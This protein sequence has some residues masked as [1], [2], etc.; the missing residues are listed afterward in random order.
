MQTPATLQGSSSSAVRQTKLIPSLCCQS[1]NPVLAHPPVRF[2]HSSCIREL[3]RGPRPAPSVAASGTNLRGHRHLFSCEPSEPGTV[4]GDECPGGSLII[5]CSLC[6]RFRSGPPALR[7]RVGVGASDLLAFSEATLPAPHAARRGC[8]PAVSCQFNLLPWTGASATLFA[9]Q[10]GPPLPLAHQHLC[11]HSFGPRRPESNVH[12]SHSASRVRTAIP[13]S[14]PAGR[15]GV[16]HASDQRNPR[17]TNHFQLV[18][19]PN[20]PHVERPSIVESK[21]GL[22]PPPPPRSNSLTFINL[23][24]NPPL[25]RTRFDPKPPESSRQPQSSSGM[26]AR[27]FRYTHTQMKPRIAVPVRP[28]AASEAFQIHTLRTT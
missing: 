14:L 7:T 19:A 12:L 11:P 25:G 24:P 27:G 21:G 13:G 6:P 26:T 1:V 17:Q 28:A 9:K 10:R 16:P 18:T 15:A 23:R 4:G 5:E 2:L 22:S 3:R 20:T 8:G